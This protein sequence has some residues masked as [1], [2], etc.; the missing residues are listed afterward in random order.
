M[1]ARFNTI[2]SRDYTPTLCML[3]LEKSGE[4]RLYAGSLHFHVTTMPRARAISVLSLAVWWAKLG[5]NNKVRHNE[6]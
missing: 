2:E 5:K 3:G 1:L 4:G 6:T